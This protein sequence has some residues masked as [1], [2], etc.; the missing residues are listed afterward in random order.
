MKHGE[1]V[2]PG[3]RQ[4]ENDKVEIG[5]PVGKAESLRAALGQQHGDLRSQLTQ[6][7]SEAVPHNRMV[8]DDQELHGPIVDQ[9]LLA[10]QD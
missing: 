6:Q 5:M 9:D 3:H 10:A 4:I 7:G 2:A 8:I 1:S